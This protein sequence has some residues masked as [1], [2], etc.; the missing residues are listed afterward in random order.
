MVSAGVKYPMRDIRCVCKKCG[1]TFLWTHGERMAAVQS[2]NPTE[3]M[4]STQKF[5]TETDRMKKPELC[6]GCTESKPVPRKS[7]QERPKR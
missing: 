1:H 3:A 5:K 2:F 4:S 6:G 7:W